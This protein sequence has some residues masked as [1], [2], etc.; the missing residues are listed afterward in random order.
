M[1][2]SVFYKFKSSREAFRKV[3]FDGTGISIFDLKKAIIIENGMQKAND[4]DLYLY[5]SSTNQEYKEDGQILPRSSSVVVVRRPAAKPGKG[6]AAY[7]AAGSGLGNLVSD[8]TKGP[9]GNTWHKGGMSKRFDG[10]KEEPSVIPAPAPLASIVQENDEA[11]AMAAMF[12]AQTANWEETQ[13]KMS[14]ATYI[15]FNRPGK[16]NAAAQQ[17]QQ[18][19]NDKPLPPSYV[20]YRCGQK[21]H[22]IQDCPTNNDREFDHKPRIKRTTGIPRSFLK[23]IENPTAGPGVMVTPE[24][25]YVVAQPDVA[26]WQKHL[27]RQKQVLTESDVRE[28]T[29]TDPTLVC[30][31]DN[32]LFRDAV[33]SPCCGTTFC[34]ECIQTHL[35]EHDFVCPQ[36]TKKVPSLDKLTKDADARNKVTAYIEKAIEASKKNVEEAQEASLGTT[37]NN[38]GGSTQDIA[39]EGGVDDEVVEGEDDETNMPQII[40]NSVPQLQA[41]VQQL[42]LMLQNPGLPK[43]VQQQ[44]EVQL[45]QLQLQLQHAQTIAMALALSST[46]GGQVQGFEQVAMIPPNMNMPGPGVFSNGMGIPGGVQAFPNQ[47]GWNSQ[48][49]PQAPQADSPYQRLPVNN[50]RKNLKRERPSDFV[51]VAGTDATKQP[52]FWE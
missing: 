38:Q 22:W 10:M 47:A 7:Y 11:A 45:Q 32:Q 12:Q 23:A 6:K 1:A 8:S 3:A 9:G 14:H 49:A 31:I 41:Q 4:F 40:A 29:P 34:E 44:T 25:G 39:T 30:P 50:R 24:G 33:K 37:M 42:S 16:P 46:Q 51:E 2:S 36:C 5:D 43:H 35:L 26:S 21:G 28:R 19:R 20:C 18:R 15:Q 13:E 52:R 17:Q 48:F 27:S